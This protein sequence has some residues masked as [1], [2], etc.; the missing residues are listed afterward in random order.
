VVVERLQAR[1][2]QYVPDGLAPQRV[3]VAFQEAPERRA[4]GVDPS[5]LAVGD[6]GHRQ[7]LDQAR[8]RVG[9]LDRQR[10]GALAGHR[11]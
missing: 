6:D 10:D 8:E 1:L 7:P 11:R 5:A 2:G 9:V 4:R 3:L